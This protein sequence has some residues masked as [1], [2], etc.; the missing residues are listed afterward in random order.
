MRFSLRW[1]FITVAYVA[2]ATTALATKSGLLADLVWGV[3]WLAISFAVVVACVGRQQQQAIAVGF[4]TLAAAN[5]AGLYLVPDRTPAMRLLSAAGYIVTSEGEVYEPNPGYPGQVHFPVGLR[6]QVST[7]NAVG[8]LAIGLI[9][10]LVGRI[11]YAYLHA[12]HRD[13]DSAN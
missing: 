13:Y 2:V 5:V 9:G 12:A 1:L 3:S 7:V 8:T 10:C 11:A 6:A 4:L